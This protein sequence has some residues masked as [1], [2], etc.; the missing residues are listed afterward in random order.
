MLGLL[1]CQPQA[2]DPSGITPIRAIKN[3]LLTS[4]TRQTLAVD[5]I[6]VLAATH[7]TNGETETRE[8]KSLAGKLPSQTSDPE[9]IDSQSLRMFCFPS[10]A[11]DSKMNEINSHLPAASLI[12]VGEG[13]LW[14]KSKRA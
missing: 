6:P 3:H 8:D 2:S 10:A 14:Q 5:F 9:L 4:V 11:S 12:F 7:L 1:F 13:R